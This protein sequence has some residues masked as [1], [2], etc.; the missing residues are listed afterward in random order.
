MVKVH[1]EKG[2]PTY[3]FFYRGTSTELTYIT[4][5]ISKHTYMHMSGNQPSAHAV[6]FFTHN[7]GINE[8]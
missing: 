4:C 2:H 3:T 7:Y 8:A 1:V 5:G 6:V